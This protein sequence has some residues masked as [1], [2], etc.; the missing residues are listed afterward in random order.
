MKLS[1]AI[2][3]VNHLKENAF[4]EEIIKGFIE[5][6]DKR[7]Y[8]EVVE[9]HIQENLLKNYDERYPLKS[10]DELL[11]DDAYCQFYIFYAISQIDAFNGEYDRYNNNMIL[12]NSY[13]SDYKQYY[14]RTHKPKGVKTIITD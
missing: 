6:C 14:N 12:Y 2:E 4:D 7:I 5:E 11:A 13:L 1:E 10:E 9:T 3:K 8:R